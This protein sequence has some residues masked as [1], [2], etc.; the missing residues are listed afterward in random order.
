MVPPRAATSHPPEFPD[1][2]YPENLSDV[3][4]RLLDLLAAQGITA[5]DLRRARREAS[6]EDLDECKRLEA[7]L[8]AQGIS[9]ED[10][11]TPADPVYVAAHAAWLRG[12]GPCPFDG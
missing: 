8:A 5:E 7:Q 3:S 10:L 12:E 11:W 9:V 4:P 1:G 6:P 2:P